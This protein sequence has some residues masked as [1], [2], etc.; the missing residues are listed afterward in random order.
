MKPSTLFTLAAI[1]FTATASTQAAQFDMK[2]KLDNGKYLV[3]NQ[4]PGLEASYGYSKHD[5]ADYEMIMDAGVKGVSVTYNVANYPQGNALYVRYHKGPFDYVVYNTDLAKTEFQG[6]RVFKN[7]KKIS[8]HECVPG[9]ASAAF[10]LE[11]D[12]AKDV[13]DD[14][15]A[16]AKFDGL[17]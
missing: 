13:Q 1:L 17:Q 10:K 5:D 6:L 7:G 2:C 15:V 14:D 9:Q 4:L 3:A 11:L 12:T 16:V 8:E